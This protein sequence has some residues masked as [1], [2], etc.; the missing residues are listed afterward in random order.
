MRIHG[1]RFHLYEAAGG[2]PPAGFDH[3]LQAGAC[4][5]ASPLPGDHPLMRAPGAI[6]TPHTGGSCTSYAPRVRRL[7]EEQLRRL[8]AGQRPLFLQ[9]AGRLAVPPAEGA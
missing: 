4:P 6:L 1:A 8:A 9:Q 2:P 5:V 7:L 3:L